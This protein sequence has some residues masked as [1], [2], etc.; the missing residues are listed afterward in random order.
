MLFF[1]LQGKK[2]H[3]THPK[4]AMRKATSLLASNWEDFLS[5]PRKYI[6]RCVPCV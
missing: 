2:V 4:L 3:I 5:F 1:N 6:V